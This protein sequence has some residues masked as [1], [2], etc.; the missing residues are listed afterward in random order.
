MPGTFT[1]F[2]GANGVN[3]TGSV[4]I[5]DASTTLASFVTTSSSFDIY[6][7]TTNSVWTYRSGLSTFNLLDSSGG[8]LTDQSTYFQIDLTGFSGANSFTGGGNDDVFQFGTSLNSNDTISGGAGNDTVRA[9]ASNL[10]GTAGTLRLSDVERLELTSSGSTNAVTLTNATGLSTLK[11]D[12]DTGMT[13]SGLL[14]SVTMVD[15]GS[16]AGA[17]SIAFGSTADVLLKGGSGNDT[18]AFG[19]TLT[20]ADTISGGAGNDT[21]TA[22]VTSLDNTTG[23]FRLTDVETLSLTGS[24]SSSVINLSNAIGLN[25]LNLAGS[26]DLSVSGLLHAVTRVNGS[27][28]AGALTLSLIYAADVLVQGGAGNDRF[29]FANSL[30][31]ADTVSGGAGD[32]TVR[33]AVTNLNAT[34]GVL[35]LTGVETLWLYGE[36]GPS[37]VDL[38]NSTGLTT[39]DASN[40]SGALTLNYSHASGITISGGEGT[41]AISAGSGNDIIGGFAGNDT[42]SGG[43]GADTLSG[44]FGDDVLYGGAGDDV[45]GY[46]A[47]D[48]GQTDVIGDFAVGDVIRIG[49]TTL[50]G[51]TSGTG[52]G[53]AAHGVQVGAASGGFTPLYIDLDGSGGTAD[54]TVQ[55]AGSFSTANLRVSGNEISAFTPVS[56]DTGG[57]GGGGGGDTTTRTVDGVTIQQT[58][59]TGSDGTRT[60]TISVP[61]VTTGRQ[62]QDPTS[63]NADIPLVTGTTGQSL[64]TAQLP[65]GVGLQV[66]SVTTTASTTTG[67]GLQGLI[68]AIQTRTQDR[69]GDQQ[70]MTG[71]GQSFLNALPPATNLTVRTI[72]PV[73]A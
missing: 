8:N 17:L 9:T 28:A 68:R 24:G 21:L 69:P 62:E 29:D 32:D 15:A 33:A 59:Q 36:G 45:F 12:G 63:T 64:L 42:L 60:E 34:T 56:T 16:A 4:K 23:A 55:L 40:V 47:T 6:Y 54:L 10:F 44:G 46:A 25:T 26:S 67:Q 58:V 20:N 49:S 73:V 48:T 3:G 51:I 2:I 37:V 70:E 43:A 52:T 11:V 71:I 39:I 7:D 61:I 14:G 22:T 35:N 27:T 57:G 1:Y 19:G 53:L 41:D 65:V 30:T 18:F 72:V 50:S 66:E 5:N 13:V 31:N 38:S